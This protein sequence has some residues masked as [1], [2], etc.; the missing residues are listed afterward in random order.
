MYRRMN[1]RSPRN[2]AIFSLRKQAKCSYF[3]LA[4]SPVNNSKKGLF[5]LGISYGFCAG[6]SCSASPIVRKT[7]RQ[8]S[9]AAVE[10]LSFVIS[11][12]SISWLI[13]Q[14]ET[15]TWIEAD[16]P[17]SSLKLFIAI[18][19]NFDKQKRAIKVGVKY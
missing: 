13:G 3:P 10:D 19:S 8:K 6:W 5:A 15:K 2:T 14:R 9:A 16:P 11:F 17:F 4:K 7:R 1:D 18:L 12:P